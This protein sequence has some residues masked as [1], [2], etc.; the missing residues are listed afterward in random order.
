M[1]NKTEK[2][3]KNCLFY[4]TFTDKDKKTHYLCYHGDVLNVFFFG[5]KRV[6]PSDSCR[7][8]LQKQR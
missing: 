4:E 8:F 7:D 3:C 1:P 2:I 5:P 6:S